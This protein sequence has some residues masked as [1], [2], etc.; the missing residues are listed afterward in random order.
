MKFWVIFLSSSF[1][2]VY[3]TKKKQIFYQQKKNSGKKTFL[4]SAFMIFEFRV[5]IIFDGYGCVQRLF[6]GTLCFPLLLITFTI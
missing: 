6:I 1:F 5:L 2:C 3:W 4:C